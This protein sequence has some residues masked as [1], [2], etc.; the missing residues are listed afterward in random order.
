MTLDYPH[1]QKT[2]DSIT[3]ISADEEQSSGDTRRDYGV[4]QAT[5]EVRDFAGTVRPVQAWRSVITE[6]GRGPVDRSEVPD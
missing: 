1:K 3:H 2:L 5:R 6:W 4:V